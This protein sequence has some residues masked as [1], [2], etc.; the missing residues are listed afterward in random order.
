MRIMFNNIVTK[1][2][3]SWRQ[4]YAKP[5]IYVIRPCKIQ[6]IVL[7]LLNNF[8]ST[9]YGWFMIIN[10]REWV[11][12]NAFKKLILLTIFI[13]YVSRLNIHIQSRK[14]NAKLIYLLSENK[15]NKYQLKKLKIMKYFRKLLLKLNIINKSTVSGYKSG[16]KVY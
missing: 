11:L 10:G 7:K 5:R 12:K 9:T 4:L 6:E 15:H 14:N 13:R 3:A 8:I 1:L 2:Y 16:S